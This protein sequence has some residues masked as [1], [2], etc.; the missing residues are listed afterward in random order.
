VVLR[1][2][3][4]FRHNPQSWLEVQSQYDLAVVEAERGEEMARRM[5]PAAA[6]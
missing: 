5:R 4:V 1:L 2:G 6:A 3:T